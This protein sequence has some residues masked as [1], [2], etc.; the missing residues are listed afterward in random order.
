MAAMGGHPVDAVIAG[1]MGAGALRKLQSEGIRVF[2]GIE[3]NV[4]ENLEVAGIRQAAGV[5]AWN[6]LAT[7]TPVKA[8]ATTRR[9]D[10][11]ELK[12]P[13]EPT[14]L[15]TL[16]TMLS[17]S[18]YAGRAIDYYL[19]RP[20]EGTL[21]DA[22]MITELTGTCGDTMKCYLKVRGRPDRGCQVPGPGMPGGRLGRHGPGRPG[23]G[24]DP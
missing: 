21:E 2:R 19:E 1:G 20:N 15:N 17:E 5:P 8:V 18:G 3:G 11:M 9:T 22:N 14:D 23:P 10:A 4:R 24:E 6:E 16:R 7:D 13:S 12:N